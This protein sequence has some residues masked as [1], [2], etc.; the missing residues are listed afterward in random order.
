[1]QLERYRIASIVATVAAEFGHHAA[2]ST[3]TLSLGP[4]ALASTK[5]LDSDS[6]FVVAEK[7]IAGPP[8]GLWT[9][10]WSRRCVGWIDFENAWP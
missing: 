9:I 2:V 6:D 1:M 7:L 4:L 10:L 8:P 5:G 3:V